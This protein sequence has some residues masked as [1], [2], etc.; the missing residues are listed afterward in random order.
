MPI[1]DL[2]SCYLLSSLV[3]YF[4]T[5]CKEN[6]PEMNISIKFHHLIH[7]CSK[8]I[9]YGPL[10]F[11][12]TINFESKHSFL[13]SFCKSSKNWKR[14]DLTIGKKYSRVSCVN[15]E[16]LNTHSEVSI[17][18][19]RLPSSFLKDNDIANINECFEIPFFKFNSYTNRKGSLILYCRTDSNLI[20]LKISNI[21]KVNNRVIF[22][23]GLFTS[24]HIHD[25]NIYIIDE[26]N[27]QAYRY[28]D[29]MMNQDYSCLNIYKYDNSNVIFPS[30]NFIEY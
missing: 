21:Y 26:L 8:M 14:P 2:N 18:K 24:H 16:A 17:S 10:R 5:F 1:I 15:F 12:S 11:V 29:Q 23:G 7:Y 20:F 28:F 22:Y 9:E 19:Y 25:T 4:L 13:K 30:Y 3:E 6:F 27:D